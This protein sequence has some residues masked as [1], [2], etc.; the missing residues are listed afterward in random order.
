MKIT[1]IHRVELLVEDPAAVADTF[2]DLFGI[3]FAYDPDTEDH[4]TKCYMAADAGIELVAPTKPDNTPAQILKEKGEG[5]LT[6]VLKVEN[7]EDAK[8]WAK[9]KG[10]GIVYDAEFTSKHRPGVWKQLSLD[11]NA[12]HGFM[13]TLIEEVYD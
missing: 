12:T 9:E 8:V 6:V 2:N 11:R 13:I 3:E 1:G 4:G 5:L 10:I 7:M